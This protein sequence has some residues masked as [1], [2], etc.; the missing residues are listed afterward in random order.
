MKTPFA[1]G[2]QKVYEH[3]VTDADAASFPSGEV[4]AVYST[5]ALTRDAEWAG[6]LFVLDMKEEGEEGIGTAVSVLHHAPAM[7]GETVT[8]TSTLEAINGNEIITPFEV[9]SGGRLIAS[10]ET[11]QKI[12]K[13]EKLDRLFEPLRSAA[14]S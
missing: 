9:K 7:I 8:I 5:F 2:D 4:H 12:V 1:P 10:G 6:R 13:K 14:N 11:R 3:L